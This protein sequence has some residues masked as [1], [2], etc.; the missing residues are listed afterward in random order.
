[1]NDNRD[2]DPLEPLF[3]HAA[4]HLDADTARPGPCLE[5]E[6]V[7]AW[8]ERRL[9][10]P[11]VTAL[12]QHAATCG[13]CRA[14]LAAFA[15]TEPVSPAAVPWWKAPVLRW[16]APVAAV[17]AA[18]IIWVVVDRGPIQEQIAAPAATGPAS[19]PASPPPSVLTESDV[20]RP[21]ERPA[22]LSEARR[23][24][25][26]AKTLKPASPPAPTAPAPPAPRAA[27]AA[28][29]EVTA[30][31]ELAADA[32]VSL[33][34]AGAPF[35]LTSPDKSVHWRALPGRIERSTDDGVTW[36][37]QP[38]NPGLLLTTGQCVTSEVCWLA[39]TAG[40][41]LRTTDGRTWTMAIPPASTNITAIH[42][43]DAL[44]AAVTTADGRTFSTSDGGQ[45]WAERSSLQE[46]PA[47]P[48]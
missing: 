20:A 45:T 39:G 41:V 34:A 44:N 18:A 29:T 24:E 22:D 5:A 15:R 36:S 26:S 38:L 48:F 17:A 1:V 30:A 14:L 21:A 31:R 25:E 32:L 2:R 33:S 4:R 23:Q 46:R 6:T 16:A 3:G 12:E 10:R 35:V 8:A 19:S 27:Q 43:A 40:A 11:E 7:A 13:R 42:P 28:R 9:A 37:A 47:T